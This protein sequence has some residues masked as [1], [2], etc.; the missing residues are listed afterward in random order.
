M[1]ATSSLAKFNSLDSGEKGMETVEI[2]PQFASG[3]GLKLGDVVSNSCVYP[4]DN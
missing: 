3:L 1:A 2:D 4:R